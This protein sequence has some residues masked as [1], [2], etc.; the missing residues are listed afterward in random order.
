[1]NTKQAMTICYTRSEG[2]KISEFDDWLNKK[3]DLGWTIFSTHCSATSGPINYTCMAILTRSKDYSV[4]RIKELKTF[5]ANC[6]S[7]EE[8]VCV[9]PADPKHD[10]YKDRI[11]S[12]KAEIGQLEEEV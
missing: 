3:I 6:E 8:Q 1:M 4:N 2:E 7:E 12:C 10:W 5:I 11:A 9:N